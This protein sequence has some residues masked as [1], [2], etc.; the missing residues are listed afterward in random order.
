MYNFT[1]DIPT[2]ILFGKGQI[3]KLTKELAVFGKRVLLAYGGGSIKKT[4]LY[5]DVI[6]RLEKDG[7][8]VT[9]STLQPVTT[10]YSVAVADTQ[11]SFGFDGL[12]NVVKYVSDHPEVNAFGGWYNS[13]NNMYYFDAT[14]IV[15][16]L[17]AAME[18]GRINKQIAIFDLANLTEI[19][20]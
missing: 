20:L 2:K 3:E 12:A 1:H 17:A 18:L 19:R 10:G 13:E 11:N 5:D 8:T 6:R 15:N 7:F 9:A 14:V 16:D 4:G